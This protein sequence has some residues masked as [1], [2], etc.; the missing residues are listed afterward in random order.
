M[1]MPDID[2]LSARRALPAKRSI[3]E[4]LEPLEQIAAAS[5]S[6]VANHGSS[7]QKGATI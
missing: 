6:L 4:L 1:Q 3:A 7:A 2:V 5:P